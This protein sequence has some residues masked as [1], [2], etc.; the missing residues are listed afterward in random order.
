ML[1]MSAALSDDDLDTSLSQTSGVSSQS[2]SFSNV[3][4]QPKVAPQK[5]NKRKSDDMYLSALQ[6]ACSSLETIK[7]KKQKSPTKRDDCQIFGDYIA[8]SLRKITNER[9]RA[10][11]Q[12]K[13]QELL[14]NF[15]FPDN[16]QSTLASDAGPSYANLSTTRSSEGYSDQ[17]SLG[18]SW[19]TN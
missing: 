8:E 5:V 11:C 14:F 12:L 16:P 3:I 19:F 13:V 2:D 10:L 1:Q 4:S 7:S 6:T 15:S 9:N 17:S 18:G